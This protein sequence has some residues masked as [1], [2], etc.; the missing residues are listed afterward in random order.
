VTSVTLVDPALT[1][2]SHR[3]RFAGQTVLLNTNSPAVAGHA[4]KFL[5]GECDPESRSSRPRA[6]ITVHIR[7]SDEGC[8]SAPWF[9]SRGHFAF[10][11][12]TRCDTFWFNLRTREVYGVATT[13]LAEDWRRW[14]A[15]IFP[16]L[17]GIL[18]ATIGVAPIHAGCLVRGGRGVLLTGSS[19]AGKSTL[20]I[21]LAKRGYALLSDEWTYLS[22]ERREIVG[23][24][25]PV[26]VK[27]L[28]DASRFFPELLACV[29]HVSL[30]GEL[31][32]EVWPDKCFGV[33]RQTRSSVNT[34]V[35]LERSLDP[36]CRFVQISAEEAIAHLSAAV[37]PLEGRLAFYYAQQLELIRGLEH[38]TC[39]RLSFNDPPDSV[40]KAL[41]DVL[42]RDG[43]RV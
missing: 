35:L 3:L 36:G 6:T 42:S 4:L 41:D 31:A 7:E 8:E 25:L 19:G 17:L 43:L 11:R 33:S 28:P 15:Q 14:S 12:F 26:P 1:L 30:N 40:A 2:C 34:I 20:T 29:P 5:A 37:E 32:Y 10:A 38:A 24:A 21:A 39:L 27:L 23:W 13:E 16:T 9:R 18:S 22:K